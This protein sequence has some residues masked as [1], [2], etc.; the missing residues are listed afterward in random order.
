MYVFTS[1][2]K[3]IMYVFTSRYKWMMYVFTKRCER[4][5]YVYTRRCK[6]IK[7]VFTWMRK[8]IMYVFTSRYKQIMYEFTK[9]CKRI[10]YVFP[11]TL[12]HWQDMT[13]GQFLGRVAN[14]CAGSNSEFFFPSS[15]CLTKTKNPVYSIYSLGEN[16]LIHT[17]L[18]RHEPKVKRKQDTDSISFNGNRFAMST[19]CNQI[20]S[21][22]QNCKRKNEGI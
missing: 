15:S 2:Y 14:T 21:Y 5:I 9:R 17:F 12:Y 20:I 7:R 3:R 11:R 6:R 4:I 19:H 10:M 8:R 16:R 22:G 13:Q 18:K 1:R